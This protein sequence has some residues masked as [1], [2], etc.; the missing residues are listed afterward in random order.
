MTMK[1]LYTAKVNARGGRDGAIRSDDGLLE[2]HLALPVAMGG[3]GNGTN[4]EQLFAAGYAACFAATLGHIGQ[5]SGTPLTA[6]EVDA[7]VDIGIQ[8]EAYTLAVRLSVRASG[9]D[10]RA[11]EALIVKA[12]SACPYAR[13]TQN[14][15]A[16]SVRIAS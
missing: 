16:S 8:D 15:I 7:E 13:A 1:V 6:V 2:A 5:A 10:S 3:P 9:V 11:L 4:P 14:N 12:K